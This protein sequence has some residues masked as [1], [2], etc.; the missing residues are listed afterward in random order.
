MRRG[1]TLL[2][3]IAFAAT[4]AAVAGVRAQDAAPRWVGGRG[5]AT[6]AQAEAIVAHRTS[7]WPA[8]PGA[9]AA[10]DGTRLRLAFW[11]AKRLGHG[12][13]DYEAVA[14]VVTSFDVVAI[15]EVMRPEPIRDLV[16][17]L[18]ADE[19]G[20][21][22]GPPVGRNRYRERYAV[23]YRRAR[24]QAP[25]QGDVHPD[26][27]DVFMREPLVVDLRA[28]HFDFSLGVMHVVWGRRRDRVAEVDALAD[29]FESVQNADPSEQDVVL[30]GDFNLEPRDVA[31]ARMLHLSGVAMLLGSPIRTTLGQRGFA[32]LYDNVLLQRQHTR[33]WTGEAGI[34]DTTGLF[35][36]SSTS[37]SRRLSDHVPVWAT[38]RTDLED[39][40]GP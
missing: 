40:D 3:L 37:T 32:S 8:L 13:K 18:G 15:A 33:E 25:E 2:C 31:W 35:A 9:P 22:V 14:R 26:P 24:V 39:D 27:T 36:G 38:F 21:V 6:R 20:A 10:P 19:W 16:E 29:V 12:T 1:R 23:I 17:L 34:V 28:G 5:R 7:G 4:T 30:V 11:N